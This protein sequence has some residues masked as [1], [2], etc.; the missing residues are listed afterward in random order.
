MSTAPTETA[1]CSQESS[2]ALSSLLLFQTPCRS[3]ALQ[4]DGEGTTLESSEVFARNISPWPHLK[5]TMALGQKD[6]GYRTLNRELLKPH[7]F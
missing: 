6:E 1:F 5:P 4:A 7:G 3:Y 2:T